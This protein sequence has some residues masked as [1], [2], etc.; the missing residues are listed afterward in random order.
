M[1]FIYEC[2]RAVRPDAIRKIWIAA[3]DQNQVAFEAA[4]FVELAGAIDFGVEAVIGAEFCKEGAF[5]EKFCSG[6]GNKEFV[7]VMRVD[8]LAGCEVEEFDAEVGSCEFGTIHHFLDATGQ[9]G[10]RN[11][12]RIERHGSEKRRRGD[13]QSAWCVLM[14]VP[15]HFAVLPIASFSNGTFR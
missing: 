13:D 7:R 1:V 11:R 15:I 8:D 14:T 5:G 4:F 6:S 9:R 3:R 12:R 2:E 10:L